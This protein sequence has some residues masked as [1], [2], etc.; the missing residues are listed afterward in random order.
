MFSADLARQPVRNIRVSSADFSAVWATAERR[1]AS[2][3]ARGVTDWYAGGV[4]V[5]C[6]WL[7]GTIVTDRTG[8]RQLPY[9]PVTERNARAY[10]ELIEAEYLAAEGLDLARPEALVLACRC[11]ATCAVRRVKIFRA[12]ASDVVDS[13]R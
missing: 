6:R 3:A 10:E 2:E 12:S 5:T 4:V 11:S 8:R 1:S 13:R 7:T 9:S